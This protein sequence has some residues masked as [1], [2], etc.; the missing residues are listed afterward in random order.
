MKGQSVSHLFK[1]AVAFS[2]TVSLI[3]LASPAALAQQTTTRTGPNGR[4]QVTT[5]SFQGTR[6][7]GQ[8]TTTRTGPSGGT[9]TT[10]R[11]YGNGQQ[12]TTRIAPNGRSQTTTRTVN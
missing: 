12:T 6:E 10:T 4:S 7:S 9:Q 5:R 1:S 2:V 8:Q 11:T 3:A